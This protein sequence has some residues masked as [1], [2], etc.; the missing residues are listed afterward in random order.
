MPPRCADQADD[1]P[2]PEANQ[3]PCASARG[4]FPG[5]D[6][7]RPSMRLGHVDAEQALTGTEAGWKAWSDQC[8]VDR[9]LPEIVQTLADHAQSPHLPAHGRRSSRR[10]RLR[11]RVAR[12]TRIGITGSAGCAMR[13]YALFPDERRVLRR[14]PRL[15]Q[16]AA[17]APSRAILRS[18]R[19]STASPAS[20]AS[21][22]WS[23]TGCWV[24]RLTAGPGRQRGLAAAA[25][26][27]YGE[28]MDAL[29]LARRVRPGPDRSGVGAAARADGVPGEDL[30]GARRGIWEVRGHG[31]I[32]PTPR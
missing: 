18:C 17:A 31:A 13:P 2:V 9:S 30:A 11:C 22:R 6:A 15:D 4:R 26:R 23:W 20:A 25:A 7:G 32:S 21:P 5:D 16:L 3:Q 29:H 27:V 14:G 10:P 12:R 1:R 8:T 28:V 19:S 24:R